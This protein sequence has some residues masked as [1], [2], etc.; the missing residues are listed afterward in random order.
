MIGKVFSWEII[1]TT[2]KIWIFTFNSLHLD[3]VGVQARPLRHL[4]QVEAAA[5]VGE[6]EHR[7]GHWKEEED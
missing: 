2:F 4:Q 7:D 6:E 3:I 5:E 1:S